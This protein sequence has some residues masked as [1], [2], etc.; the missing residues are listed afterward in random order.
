MLR[1]PPRSTRTDTLFPDTTRFRAPQA[2]AVGADLVGEED[3]AV[4]AV[5]DAPEFELEVD[6]A[7]ADAGEQ[8]RHEIV[9]AQRHVLNVVQF[10]AAAP[11]EA[12]D[13]VL[14]DQGVAKRIVL[15]AIF[16]QGAGKLRSEEHTSELQS[17]MR[18]SYD[19]FCWK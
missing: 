2:A 16:D 18:I 12:F 13:M 6:Q 3:A 8:P 14:G 10:L 17:L 5:P 9:D 19:G 1:R 15:V 7:D 4:I 11:V